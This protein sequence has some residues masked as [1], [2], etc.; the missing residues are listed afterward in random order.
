MP[1]CK[2]CSNSFPS[3]I[4]I[5]NEYKNISQRKYCLSCSPFGLH[6]TRNLNKQK[7]ILC[8]KKCAKC[9]TFKDA[10][11]FYIRR[12]GNNLSPYCKICT[13]K[14]CSQRFTRIKEQCVAYKGGKCENC[15][16]NRF[17]GALDFHHKNPSQKEFNICRRRSCNI[18]KLKPELDK[19]KLLCSNCHREEHGISNGTFQ[20]G[21][22][23][24]ESGTKLS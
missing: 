5:N 6:N 12:N 1:I 11:E 18:E 9:S 21:L 19:C 24:L 4:K 16:Y 17:I 23:E 14:E 8:G 2:K 7:T 15:G 13:S 3:S 20:T 22:P 10:K